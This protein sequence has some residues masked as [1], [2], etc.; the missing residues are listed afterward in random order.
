M[1][2]FEFDKVLHG[3]LAFKVNRR[4]F[5][6]TL[7]QE[8][9]VRAGEDEGRP[10]HKMADLG[11]WSNEQLAPLIPR[12]VP[13]CKIFVEDNFV[14]ARPPNY[15]RPFKIFPL[16]SPAL[17]VF[18]AINGM[19]SLLEIS[20]QFQHATEWDE[21]RSFAYVRGFFLWLTVAMVCQPVNSE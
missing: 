18:N 13:G 20:Q 17:L 1:N 7:L 2:T 16:D 19:Q 3:Y 4:Q 21:E 14:W 6:S 12:I 8:L 15:I 11:T 10:A 5:F 9:L